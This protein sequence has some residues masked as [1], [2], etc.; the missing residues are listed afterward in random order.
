MTVEKPAIDPLIA[1]AESFAERY[2][3]GDRL[4]VDEFAE[5]HPE[6]SDRIREIFPA[7]VVM[8]DC[9]SPPNEPP[10]LDDVLDTEQPPRQIGDYRIVREIGRGGM[11]VVFEAEQMSLGRAVAL[12]VLTR[13]LSLDARSLDRFRAEARSAGRL[14]HPR[15]VPVHDVGRAEDFYYYTMQLIDGQGLDVVLSEIQSLRGST[16]P[17][18][19]STSKVPARSDE[20]V[21]ALARTMYVDRDYVPSGREG[22]SSNA[23]RDG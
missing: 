16:G 13:R 21:Q 18:A 2:R 20:T 22:S 8:E 9:A 5:Q 10:D 3:R 6:F 14:H 15:I 7:L 1:L 19:G 11:G 17:R 4:T 12:K 23:T